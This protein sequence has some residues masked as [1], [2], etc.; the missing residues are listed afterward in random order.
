M[1]VTPPA[2]ITSPLDEARTIDS[3]FSHPQQPN[4][5]HG[6]ELRYAAQM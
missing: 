2:S 5:R 1:E 6:L 3:H 4:S